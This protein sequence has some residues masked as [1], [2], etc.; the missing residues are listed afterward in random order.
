MLVRIKNTSTDDD[1]DATASRS[2]LQ[3]LNKR[4]LVI[5]REQKR[6]LSPVELEDLYGFSQS[7]QAKQ[8][9]A[10]SGSA[11]PFSK[12]GGKFIRYDRIEIDRWLEDHQVQGGAA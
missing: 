6:W 7:W 10:E 2:F 12:I 11:L 8:R 5:T 1:S 4:N 9:M 3:E